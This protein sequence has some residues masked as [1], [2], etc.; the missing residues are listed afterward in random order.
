MHETVRLR[1]PVAHL[2]GQPV[3]EVA[4]QRRTD[5]LAE[6]EDVAASAI[7]RGISDPRP[8]HDVGVVCHH[9]RVGDLAVSVVARARLARHLAVPAEA[10]LVLVV[11]QHVGDE[12]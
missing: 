8:D 7:R 3:D 9:P 6:R 2:A 11:L 12:I 1:I 5:A 10:P 4:H